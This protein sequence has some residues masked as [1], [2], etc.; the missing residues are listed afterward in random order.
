MWHQI[1]NVIFCYRYLTINN[2]AKKYDYKDKFGDI[3]SNLLEIKC[4]KF[5]SD[6]FRCDISIVL[7][8]WSYFFPDTVYISLVFKIN[9][10]RSSSWNGR[11][12]PDNLASVRNE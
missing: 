4:T 9:A 12:H 10:V 6:L 7:Y 1:G 5:Y 8:L 2:F 11:T 3:F